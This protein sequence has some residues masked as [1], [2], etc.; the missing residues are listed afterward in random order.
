MLDVGSG[1]LSSPELSTRSRLGRRSWRLTGSAR[2][3]VDVNAEAAGP[4]EALGANGTFV[5]L[6]GGF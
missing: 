6:A 3:C 1:R 4:V 5:F 2:V